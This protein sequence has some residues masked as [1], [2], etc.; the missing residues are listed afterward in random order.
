MVDR[1][2][3]LPITRQCLLLD[4]AR[5]T[6]Y[7]PEP[8]GESPENLAIMEALDKL[9]MERPTRGSRT[10]KD[11]LE[12]K[13]IFVGRHK[14][15][16]LMALIGIVAVYPK[17][18]TTIA[19]KAHKI[20]PYLLRTLRI[21]RPKQVYAADIT[22]IPMAKG[23]V[24]LVAVIDWYSR[25]VL[26]H[27]ISNTLDAG[28]CVEAL[29]EAIAV[30]GAPEI[31]NTDQGSQFTSAEFTGVLTAHGV[32]ISMDG[33]G[34]WMDNVYVERLWRSLKYEEVYLKAYATV[35]DARRSIAIYFD[36]FNGKRKHSSLGRRTPDDVFFNHKP[37]AQAA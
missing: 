31:F 25:K 17:V 35:E 11:A 2:H 14:I 24:Y 23:F 36:Y 6:V 5:S 8:K 37:A 19:N 7:S 15:R 10:M 4:V 21:D 34:R 28:F 20:Y 12:D 32:K 29:E 1:S 30:Y 33:K 3:S 16:R 26:S 13:G 9:Y 27:R 18:R 22:Y